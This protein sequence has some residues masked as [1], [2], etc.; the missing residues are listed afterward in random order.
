MKS[1]FARHG[2]LSTIVSDNSP[3]YDSAEMK[4]LAS[5]YGF[6]YITSIPHYPQSNGQAERTVKTVKSLL[7]DLP[8]I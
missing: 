3:Q 7:Q 6:K 5:L 4:T 8:D 2:I 1:V